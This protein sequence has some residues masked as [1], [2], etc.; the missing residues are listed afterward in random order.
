MDSR[1]TWLGLHK[2]VGHDR[3]THEAP[4]SA[5]NQWQLT[6][7]SENKLSQTASAESPEEEDEVDE[8]PKS[9]IPKVL[10]LHL[11]KSRR[12]GICNRGH[13]QW[14]DEASE[15][16]FHPCSPSFLLFLPLDDGAVAPKASVLGC[17]T[18][19]AFFADLW[20]L[21]ESDF[22][23]QREPRASMSVALEDIKMTK[24]D[25]SMPS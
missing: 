14:E 11:Q 18:G 7:I 25:A 5:C 19:T 21:L 22:C 1:L 3:D 4:R 6:S 8:G 24:Q 20:R 10:I 15:L 17:P 23:A 13:D 16:M 2:D 12:V 9:V